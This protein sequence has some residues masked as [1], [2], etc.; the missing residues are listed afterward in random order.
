MVISKTACIDIMKTYMKRKEDIAT[1]SCYLIDAE[2]KIL[3]RLSATIAKLLMGKDSADYTPHVDSGATVIVINAEKVRL[4]GKKS[5]NKS[6]KSYS[7]YPGG[8]KET[9]IKEVLERKPEYILRHAVRG[10]ISKNKLLA[11]RM[12]R[13]KI[14]K[15]S[16]HPHKAQKPILLEV[17]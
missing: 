6:Y 2:D 1:R 3:G 14:Y 17:D 8:L 10:M 4:S 16:E 7:G 15:G 5:M 9:N 11:R 13:L 12:A